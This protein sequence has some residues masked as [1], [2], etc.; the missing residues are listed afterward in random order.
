[1]LITRVES[2]SCTFFFQMDGTR[3]EP[4]K[5]LVLRKT[6]SPPPASDGAG[7]SFGSGIDILGSPSTKPQEDSLS[8]EPV[9]D[10]DVSASC[11]GCFTD[12]I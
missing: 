2:W 7:A 11:L 10:I 6:A 1:M 3:S 8:S 12:F 5:I 4:G 9:A